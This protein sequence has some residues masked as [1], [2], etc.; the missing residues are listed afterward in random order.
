MVYRCAILDDY[1]NLALTLADWSKVR[2]RV[3]ITVFNTFPLMDGRLVPT[4]L[5]ALHPVAQN[6]IANQATVQ[7]FH[8]LLATVTAYR[9]SMQCGSQL[10]CSCTCPASGLRSSNNSTP[11]GSG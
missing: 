3:D 10:R 2:D 5:F 7:F 8:R 1:L 6:F 11:T 4:T 9:S